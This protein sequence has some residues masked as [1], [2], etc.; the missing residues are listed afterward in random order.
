MSTKSITRHLPEVHSLGVLLL[1]IFALFAP[2]GL[3]FAQV[4]APSSGPWDGCAMMSSSSKTSCCCTS[5]GTVQ[6]APQGCCSAKA[7]STDSVSV[8]A[9]RCTC[10]SKPIPPSDNLPTAHYNLLA[11]ESDTSAQLLAN[12]SAAGSILASSPMYPP[13]PTAR[14]SLQAL[15]TRG[16]VPI[17]NELALPGSA[18]WLG[19]L[20]GTRTRLALLATNRC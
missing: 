12:I 11:P 13:L 15:T 2:I 18:H 4:S 14:D 1:L 7:P 5:T 20:R 16:T 10:D 9:P 17:Q 3:S 8:T 6:P 19:L